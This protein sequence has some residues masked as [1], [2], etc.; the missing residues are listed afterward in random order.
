MPSSA[1]RSESNTPSLDG[2][3]DAVRRQIFDAQT[4]FD[5]YLALWPTPEM[6]DT[7][8]YW[9]GFFVPTRHA[10]YER[11][12]IKVSNSLDKKDK[13][14]ASLYRLLTFLGQDGSVH[15]TVNVEQLMQRLEA[16][17][18]T[19]ESIKEYRD[20]RAAHYDWDTS[21][22][23]SPVQVG[24]AKELLAELETIFNDISA[25]LRGN[26]WSFRPSQHSHTDNLMR[27]LKTARKRRIAY[28]QGRAKYFEAL[29]KRG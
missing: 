17:N 7:L 29:S 14:A 27:T 21:L 18:S 22:S 25:A 2:L 20:K 4:H 8:N 5:I 12:L 16:L 26:V 15:S 24:Q 28:Y 3:L 6:V 9:R 1:V 11:F 13:R 23:S 10:H 19:F